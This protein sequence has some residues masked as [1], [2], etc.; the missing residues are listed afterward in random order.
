MHRVNEDS[1]PYS[2]FNLFFPTDPLGFMASCVVFFHFPNK[3]KIDTA[4][5]A[6]FP[7][8]L[9]TTKP[10]YLCGYVKYFQIIRHDI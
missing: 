3:H 5:K 1:V 2:Y 4:R 10:I 9:Q 6:V 7:S 8:E